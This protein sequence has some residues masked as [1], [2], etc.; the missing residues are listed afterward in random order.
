MILNIYST[1]KQFSNNIFTFI[2][3]FI[4]IIWLNQINLIQH[5]AENNYNKLLPKNG[6][7]YI[8]NIVKHKN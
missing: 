1:W 6:M 2:L 7:K 4:V 3:F 8:N 5:S